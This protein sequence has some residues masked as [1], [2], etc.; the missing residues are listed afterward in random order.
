M[1][2][3]TKKELILE[4]FNE[5]GFNE[6]SDDEIRLINER[7]VAIHGRG[8]AASPA[9][10][11]NILIAAGKRV[12]YHDY[13]TSSPEPDQYAEDFAGLLKFDTLAA[14]ESS[15]RTLDRLYRRFQPMEMKRESPAAASLPSE[16]ACAPA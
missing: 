2:G 15:I 4:I 6:L 11:A 3:K 1:P 16:A 10:I 12:R 9:Y 8:G 5:E 13:L 7:L 14:A